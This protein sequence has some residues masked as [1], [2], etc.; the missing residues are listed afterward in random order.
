MLK[1][2]GHRVEQRDD[3]G[4]A[5]G[6]R[7]VSPRRRSRVLTAG[8]SAPY[9][10]KSAIAG[11]DV[12]ARMLRG[13]VLALIIA[14]T[15]CGLTACISLEEM[16]QEDE[17]ACIGYGFQPGTPDFAGCLQREN[18]ARR[19]RAQFYGS[20]FPVWVDRPWWYM[21]PSRSR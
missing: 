11:I 15:A 3:R 18:L 13:T 2:I 5:Q 12:E 16:R 10:K 20:A 6:V 21:P 4:K 9:P 8:Q 7:R 19:E 1:G 14:A 17:A